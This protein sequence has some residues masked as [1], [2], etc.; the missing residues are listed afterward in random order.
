MLRAMHTMPGEQVMEAPWL[1]PLMTLAED[2]RLF[3]IRFD[4]DEWRNLVASRRGFHEFTVA[5]AHDLF[6]KLSVPAPCLIVGLDAR[7]EFFGGEFLAKSLYFGLITSRSPISTLESRIKVRHCMRIQPASEARLRKLVIQKP[8][9]KNLADRLQDYS[10]VIGL[11]PKLAS[12]VVERLASIPANHGAM[13]AVAESLSSPKRYRNAAAM[14]EDAIRTAL[15]AFGLSSDDQAESLELIQGR[16]TGLGRIRFVEDSVVEHDARHVPGYNLIESDLTGR[17]VFTKNDQRLEVYTANRRDLEHVLGVDLIYLNAT[18]QNIVMLQYK[19]L[20]PVDDGS[21]TDWIYRPD[22]KLD[23]EIRRMRRFA[24]DYPPG[25]HEYRLNS[26]V[27]YIKFV[28]RDGMI[29][30]GGIITPIDHFERLRKDPAC[31]GPKGGLRI[32][33]DGLA[34]RYMR[35]GAFLD[36]IRAGYIG[37]HAET[38]QHLK[39]LVDAV[40]AND[41]AVVAAIQSGPSSIDDA[42][43]TDDDFEA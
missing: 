15:Q 29:R 18:R 40:L 1:R 19:M 13:R 10:S 3:V 28:K 9:A 30:S 5:R 7:E 17:A 38:A 39:V 32:S 8:Y 2:K 23:E 43:A 41:R 4:E 12:H 31:K 36:L 34:G 24:G 25:L 21:D 42:G 33:Y 11:S 20:E 14:Q 6:E 16:Q 35:Q 26:T 27:F 37:A 22:R